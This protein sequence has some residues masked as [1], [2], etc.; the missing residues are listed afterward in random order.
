MLGLLWKYLFLKY[1]SGTSL[2]NN[3]H[4]CGKISGMSWG[5]TFTGMQI[6]R[7]THLIRECG[8]RERES[9]FQLPSLYSLTPLCFSQFLGI[10]LYLFSI[11]SRWMALCFSRLPSSS[12]SSCS[13]SQT[14]WR[15]SESS[16][17]HI[18]TK[19]SSDTQKTYLAHLNRINHGYCDAYDAFFC[20]LN[21]HWIL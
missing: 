16:P 18:R 2:W 8:K 20:W 1:F 14:I 6:P 10:S 7:E 15:F 3:F 12:S 11:V 17:Y 13:N 4:I 21:S 9:S 5:K 19:N